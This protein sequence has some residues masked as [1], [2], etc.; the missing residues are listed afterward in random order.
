MSF[1][2][3]YKRVRADFHKGEDGISGEEGI[4]PERLP[5]VTNNRDISFAKKR[6]HFAMKSLSSAFRTR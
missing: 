3:L 6:R 1:V 4:C 2:L 5:Y